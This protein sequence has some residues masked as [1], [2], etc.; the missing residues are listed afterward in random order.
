[1]L[2]FMA[3]TVFDPASTFRNIKR[4]QNLAGSL[5]LVF[6]FAIIM[7][8]FSGAQALIMSSADAL[9]TFIYAFGVYLVLILMGFFVVSL[10]IH[11]FMNGIGC[12]SSYSSLLTVL[13]Y[14][15]AIVNL[16]TGILQTLL[17]LLGKIMGMNVVIGL[18]NKD[19]FSIILPGGV[20]AVFGFLAA[21]T[22]IYG[23]ILYVVAARECY[24]C[25]LSAAT[26]IVLFGVG[27]TLLMTMALVMVALTTAV[28]GG[29]IV[30]LA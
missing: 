12:K 24:N 1:M 18:A 10:L 14:P 9:T 4:H 20:L 22:M 28:G 26:V 21:A 17:L 29:S 13:A 23:I 27:S 25:S 7:A 8:L 5:L 11:V 15:F 3:G 19:Y 6:L 2:E 16:V 30:P